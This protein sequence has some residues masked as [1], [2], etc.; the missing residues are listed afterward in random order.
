MSDTDRFVVECAECEAVVTF[1]VLDS[2]W[3]ANTNAATWY[4]GYHSGKEHADVDY[5]CAFP[6]ALSDVDLDGSEADR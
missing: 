1:D 5:Q 2:S 6:A 4:A 3:F